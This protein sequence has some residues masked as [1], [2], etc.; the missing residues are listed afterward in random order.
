MTTKKQA[1]ICVERNLSDDE[2]VAMTGCHPGCVEFVRAWGR[3]E[4]VELSK[5]HEWVSMDSLG[6]DDFRF[7]NPSVY[8][9]APRRIHVKA[10]LPDGTER[11]AEF[12]KPISDPP[13]VGDTVYISRGDFAP[14]KKEWSSDRTDHQLRRE[15]RV[16]K[17]REQALERDKAM[18]WIS[19]GE[20]E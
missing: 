9:I 11:E 6:T 5:I 3:G 8:R 2:I 10:T 18:I 13:S 7:A 16:F 20:V 15:G 19:G 4:R 1:E 14:D 12:P 17:T